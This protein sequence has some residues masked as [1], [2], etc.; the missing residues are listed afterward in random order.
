MA[1]Q[2][3]AG[4]SVFDALDSNHDGRISRAEFERAMAGTSPNA[5][6]VVPG[7][8]PP[9]GAS[10]SVSAT[11]YTPP[12]SMA[13]APAASSYAVPVAPNPFA[14][15]A[16]SNPFA[17]VG[18]GASF[19]APPLPP[20]Q[21]APVNTIVPKASGILPPAT[22]AGTSPF[23]TF[24]RNHHGLMSREEL[25][26]SFQGAPNPFAS[27]YGVGSYAYPMNSMAG[28]SPTPPMPPPAPPYAS[29]SP[30]VTM[31]YSPPGTA[32]C[33]SP[34]GSMQLPPGG[35]TQR[36][37]PPMVFQSASAFPT[38]IGGAAF[39]TQTGGGTPP[40]P[41]MSS[42]F[43]GTQIYG[44]SQP[45]P[46]MSGTGYGTTFLPSMPPQASQ[47]VPAG[48]SPNPFASLPAQ[49]LGSMYVPP[50]PP[51]TLPSSPS[52]T[53]TYMPTSPPAV[54]PPT[55]P[56]TVP[57]APST[58]APSALYQPSLPA[59]SPELPAQRPVRYVQ[60]EYIDPPSE[61]PSWQLQP[62]VEPVQKPMVKYDFEPEYFEQI[63]EIPKTNVEIIERLVEV[64]E[65][66]IV[67]RIIE[68]P[69]IQEVVREIPGKVEV[70][71]TT[72]EV[73]RIEIQQRE[74]VEEVPEIEYVDRF[75][76]VPIVHEIVRRIPR[77]EVHEIPVE[78]IIQVPKKV[79]QEIEQP[80]YRAVPHLVRKPVQRQIPVPKPTIQQMEVV[81]QYPEYGAAAG[82]GAGV[83][84][85]AVQGAPHGVGA[86]TQCVG[87]G[88]ATQPGA[89]VAQA[90]VS[91]AA[92]QAA[93]DAGAEAG[94]RSQAQ[95]VMVQQAA[96]YSPPASFVAAPPNVVT[97]PGQAS[98]FDQLDANHD[99]LPT[100]D[101]LLR[102]MGQ[103]PYY[104]G[105]STPPVAPM[106]VQQSNYQYG[107]GA[108][109]GTY[110]GAPAVG[111][112]MT[113]P[114]SYAAPATVM[115]LQS[116]VFGGGNPPATAAAT[117]YN[118]FA[119]QVY[120][121]GAAPGPPG[122]GFGPPTPP[123]PLRSAAQVPSVFDTIDR[124]HDGIITRDEFASMQA[125]VFA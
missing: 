28:G 88:M 83:R 82:Q 29:M 79:I 81:K 31:T 76:E 30:G 75:V 95:S 43:Y 110:V 87:S 123:V 58:Y 17:S 10:I 65:P 20:A 60:A 59:P 23:D 25:V 19:A 92:L 124:N 35:A 33:A 117:N 118:P 57:M 12:G 24:D 7:T 102:S 70:R 52:L 18:P 6:L 71:L 53:P 4:T 93:F 98:L 103:V 90:A 115:P 9:G 51:L 38:Q 91:Q 97:V 1:G 100:R 54:P 42:A 94:R 109:V 11:S 66:Q 112:Q 119:S 27:N 36:S 74:R 15:M 49:P 104:S 107:P 78:R 114:T 47:L 48:S 72:R 3:P 13:V 84:G 111:S 26:R 16:L 96:S 61:Q 40:P 116:M 120:Y 34:P 105:A 67:D 62:P 41:P 121:G 99:G 69:Q 86:A 122:S 5:S 106:T 125:P 63:T 21:S 73:P 37:A 8:L 2:A 64:P 39:P 80:V 14:S 45:T 113:L 108:P 44:P 85:A 77:I 89:G 46:P 50:G 101:E 55:P 56:P 68:V 22:A 32:A